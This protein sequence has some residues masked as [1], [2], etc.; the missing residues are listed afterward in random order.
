MNQWN[1]VRVAHILVSMDQVPA[2]SVTLGLH[3]QVVTLH[4]RSAQPGHTP[5]SCRPNALLAYPVLTPAQV[6]EDAHHVKEDQP[7]VPVLRSAVTA[8]QE[9][10]QMLEEHYVNRVSPERTL[11]QKLLDA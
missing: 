5:N 2:S 10:T 4:V 6:Q 7:L 9:D 8:R 1:N 11:Q 3:L